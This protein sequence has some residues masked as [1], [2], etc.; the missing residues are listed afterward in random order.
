MTQALPPQFETLAS[1]RKTA[2]REVDLEQAKDSDSVFVIRD[3]ETGQALGTFVE[4]DKAEAQL[5]RD[6]Y[7]KIE[8]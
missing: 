4:Q 3:R 1:Y 8:A 6:N 5:R 2:T 7:Q